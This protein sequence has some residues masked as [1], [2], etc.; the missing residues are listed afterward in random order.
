MPWKKTS[1]LISK[2][3]YRNGLGPI[4]IAGQVCREAE[5]LYP[6]LYKAVSLKDGCLNLEIQRTDR[7]KLVMIQGKLIE[8]LKAYSTAQNLPPID[9]I[10]LTFYS[11]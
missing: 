2:N 11:E 4:L 10:R 7:L 6:G 3:M 9:R 8:D 5:R 1:Q